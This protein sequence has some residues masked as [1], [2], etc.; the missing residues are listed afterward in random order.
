MQCEEKG[1]PEASGRNDPP[2]VIANDVGKFNV[3][4]C[5]PK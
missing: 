5:R 2:I 1:H 3:S 4:Y